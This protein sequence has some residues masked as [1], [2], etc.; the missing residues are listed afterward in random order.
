ML[1]RPLQGQWIERLRTDGAE[2]RLVT[3]RG[4]V[5]TAHL[6]IDPA[7]VH[8]LLPRLDGGIILAT[9]I[10]EDGVLTLALGKASESEPLLLD[11]PA[12]WE[13]ALPRGAGLTA[14]D[15]GLLGI[16]EEVG[17]LTATPEAMEQWSRSLPDA[18]DRMVLD[19]GM[20]DWVTPADVVSAMVHLGVEVE[21]R[22]RRGVE[23]LARLIARG[24]LEAGV[25]EDD[26]FRPSVEPPDA[27]IEHVATVWF[28]LTD[29][30]PGAGHIAWFRITPSGE[31]R[32]AA[33]HG[34][35]EG[36]AAP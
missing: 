28:A 25:I 12:P 36:D 22:A 35:S 30:H 33:A 29:P 20:D 14:Q 13:L 23:A 34:T 17:P 7:V 8:S 26:G 15:G 6:R 18:L 9:T 4:A 10:A 31:A 32:W 19:D 1:L 2:S 27:V 3:S 11:A 21:N 16:R 24:D 5:L